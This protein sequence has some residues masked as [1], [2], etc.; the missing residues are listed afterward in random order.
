MLAAAVQL[1]AEKGFAATSINDIERAAGLSIGSGGTY[2]H[3]SSKEAML[4]TAIENLLE[5][6]HDRLDPEPPSL[7]VG[8]Q[9][10]IDFIRDNRQL[11][12][13]LSRDLEV[14][15]DL[16][17]RVV[18]EF[19]AHSFQLAADRTAAFAPHLDTEAVAAMLGSA[20]VG[21]A[22]LELLVDWRPLAIDD[23]RF[24]A[25]LSSVYLH[26]LTSEPE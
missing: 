9:E 14:F 16:R 25:I 3:F 17:A 18:E 10:S 6:L 13:I 2:R 21:Y 1:F 26:L 23:D 8:F 7:E 12:R 15:P 4:E 5:D 19:L 11:F 20:T 22:L 24:I